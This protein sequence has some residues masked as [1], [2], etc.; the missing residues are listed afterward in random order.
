MNKS[1]MA[2]KWCVL[3][4]IAFYNI[5]RRIRDYKIIDF[6][7]ARL[8]IGQ[9]HMN[10]IC[11]THLINPKI[12]GLRTPKMARFIKSGNMPCVLL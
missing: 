12:I 10:P 7:V 1:N 2:T 4:S 9:G 11:Q 5:I 3:D 8:I 6:W